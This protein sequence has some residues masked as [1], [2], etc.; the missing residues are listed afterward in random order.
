M[1]E[2]TGLEQQE[3]PMNVLKRDSVL[4]KLYGKHRINI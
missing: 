4:K 3:K 2:R 1:N